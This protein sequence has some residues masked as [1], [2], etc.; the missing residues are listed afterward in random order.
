[1]AENTTCAYKALYFNYENQMDTLFECPESRIRGENKCAFHS[2]RQIYTA[3]EFQ[4]R[5]NEKIRHGTSNNQAIL[6]IGYNFSFAFTFSKVESKQR[7]MPSIEPQDHQPHVSVPVYFTYARFNAYFQVLNFHF[8]AVYFD[9]AIFDGEISIAA[10]LLEKCT[11]KNA[12]F[13][14]RTIFTMTRMVD[15]DFTTTIFAFQVK[16]T[17]AIFHKCTFLASRFEAPANFA[18]VTFYGKLIYLT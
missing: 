1:M 6:F 7:Y 15:A 16:F 14:N 4:Q 9:D 11:F 13:N 10:S 2:Q 3:E 17:G 8:K 5:I 12:K 18:T